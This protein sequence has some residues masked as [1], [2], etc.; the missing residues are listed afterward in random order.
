MISSEPFGVCLCREGQVV[1]N[2]TS[3]T[4][5]L[6]PG[7]SF[8]IRAAVVGQKNGT[9]PGVVHAEFV[10]PT[11][12]SLSALQESQRTGRVCTSLTYTAFSLDQDATLVLTAE[13]TTSTFP[14]DLKP[15]H[16]FIEFL[17]C[18]V[19]FFLSGEGRCDCLP[20]LKEINVNISCDI[21]S[22]T[23]HLSPPFWIGRLADSGKLAYQICPFDYCKGTAIDIMLNDTDHQCDFNRSGTLCG[24]CRSGFS[25]A[26]GSSQC[27]N[28][29][30]WYPGVLLTLTFLVAGIFLVGFL[31]LCNLTVSD[32]T[33]NGLIFYANIVHMIHTT[34]FPQDKVSKSVL[35]PLSVFIAWLNLDFGFEVCLYDSM[36]TY[37]KV[38]L[39]FVFPIYI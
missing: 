12:T 34:F 16:V 6:Y 2:E 29:S 13:N 10:G 23:I 35:A 39:Q 33:I 8:H 26:L 20:E 15:P 27:M 3:I 1:C 28:C 22:Q 14:V 7:D 36:D 5:H 32:G 37:A 30:E 38:W 18:P 25:L 21:S 11:N 17:P 19:A 4:K 9:V 24:A 31:T